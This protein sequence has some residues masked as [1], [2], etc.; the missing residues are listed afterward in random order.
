MNAN[1]LA[2]KKFY[3][4]ALV[5]RTYNEYFALRLFKLVNIRFVETAQRIHWDTPCWIVIFS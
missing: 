1:H 5:D 4:A 3:S 2:D